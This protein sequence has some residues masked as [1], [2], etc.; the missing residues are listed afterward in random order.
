MTIDTFDPGVPTTWEV[1]M[2]EKRICTEGDH[3]GPFPAS[4]Y[5]WRKLAPP[6]V[7]FGT[8]ISCWHRNTVAAICQLPLPDPEPVQLAA[9]THVTPSA[10]SGQ[11]RTGK[12]RTPRT[13]QLANVS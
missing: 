8:R 4:R 10:A 11:P 1:W 7:K 13:S 6:P 9:T 3:V 12:R 5:R 2:R